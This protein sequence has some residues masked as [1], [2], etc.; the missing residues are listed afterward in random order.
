MTLA[1]IDL[2]ICKSKISCSSL[3]DLLTVYPLSC[4]YLRCAFTSGGKENIEAAMEDL[5]KVAELNSEMEDNVQKRLKQVQR[6]HLH[7]TFSIPP[8]T[9]FTP[10]N[11][12]CPSAALRQFPCH[13]LYIPMSLT[14]YP[15]LGQGST[16]ACEYQGS[17]R[18]IRNW[19]QRY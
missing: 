18:C 3:K 1:P 12:C 19:S 11:S 10:F 7:S 5:K 4:L 6:P 17:L 8:S 2:C 15:A 9:S 16:Q 13:S 14:V